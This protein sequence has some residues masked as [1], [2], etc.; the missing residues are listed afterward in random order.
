[1][2][3]EAVMIAGDNK[4][5]AEAVPWTPTIAGKG[6]LAAASFERLDILEECVANLEA[7]KSKR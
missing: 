3:V 6:G 2:R 1:M 7:K 4:R 5:T